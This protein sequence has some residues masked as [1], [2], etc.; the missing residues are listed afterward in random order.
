[1]HGVKAALIEPCAV[2]RGQR[3]WILWWFQSSEA[4]H[5]SKYEYM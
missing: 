5:W 1:M 4:W 3:P 2:S